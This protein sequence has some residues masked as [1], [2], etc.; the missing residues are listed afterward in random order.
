[1]T[2]NLF[3]N[4]TLDL[5]RSLDDSPTMRAIRAL[6]ESPT[7]RML[8]EINDSPMLRL[9]QEL[10]DSPSMRLFRQ[11][12]ESPAMRIMRNLEESPS[13][14]IIRDLENSPAFRAIHDLQNSPALRVIEA[15]DVS[16]SLTAFSK[17]S[18]QINKGFSALTFSEA[19]QLLV[20]EIIEAENDA[21]LVEEVKTKSNRAPLS[22][23]SAEFY[24]NLI[25]ALF[26]YYLSQM[27]A[28]ESEE[29]LLERMELLENTI[30]SQ[31]QMLESNENESVFLV[32]DREIN[33]RE[34]PSIDS[35]VIEVL[36][37]NKKVMEL[38]RQR[39][40]IQVEYFDH[41]NNLSKVGWVHSG[42]LILIESMKSRGQAT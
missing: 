31:L 26:L 35:E 20:D 1:M 2:N 33:F 14:Q 22:P 4:A 34:G 39:E 17:I 41:I 9:M 40:W 13:F 3:K 12:E 11:I 42:Y 21:S 28:T 38:S 10:E 5:L 32:T 7:M 25:F 27:S 6:E 15:L 29:R 8:E 37:R 18:E 30:S 23:L 36:P 16:P 19:Y 24:L